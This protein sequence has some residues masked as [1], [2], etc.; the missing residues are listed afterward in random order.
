MLAMSI[1][2]NPSLGLVTIHMGYWEILGT[3]GTMAASLL[4]YAWLIGPDEMG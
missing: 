3:I 4:V 2:N 1:A